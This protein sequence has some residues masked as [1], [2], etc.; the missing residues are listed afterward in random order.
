MAQATETAN[1]GGIGGSPQTIVAV[2][3]GAV[4]ALVGVL[5]PVLGGASGE[6]IIFGR[7]YLHDAIHLLSGLAGLAA[8][9]YAG[10]QY[11]SEYNKALGVVYLLVT[12]LGFVLF[13]LFADLIALNTA[14][15]FLHLALAVVFLGVGFALGE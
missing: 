12:I 15:N 14:D 10:G 1:A 9:Y 8:G 11:A 4:L 5:G 7:N 2:L 6:L 3:F 13:D